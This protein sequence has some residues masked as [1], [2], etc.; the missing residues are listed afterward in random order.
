MKTVKEK[1]IFMLISSVCKD[2]GRP[3]SPHSQFCVLEI[4]EVPPY[5]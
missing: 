3:M 1:L 2:A 5:D 4:P